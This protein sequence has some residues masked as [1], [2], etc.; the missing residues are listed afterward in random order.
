MAMVL[1]YLLTLTILFLQCRCLLL[2]TATHMRFEEPRMQWLTQFWLL[3]QVRRAHG[4]LF[5]N[6]VCMQRQV[7]AK[8]PELKPG[9]SRALKQRDSLS[10]HMPPHLLLRANCGCFCFNQFDRTQPV[11][12]SQPNSSNIT[13]GCRSYRNCGTLQQQN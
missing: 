6:F 7:A 5:L 8:S 12:F 13:L 10:L 3:A 9:Q 11:S 2:L 1:S 4:A